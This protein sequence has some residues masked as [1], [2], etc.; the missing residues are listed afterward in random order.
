[1][2]FLLK[3]DLPWFLMKSSIWPFS[4]LYLRLNYMCFE[5]RFDMFFE[6]QVP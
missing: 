5:C 3:D 2:I 4:W 6:K 1:L